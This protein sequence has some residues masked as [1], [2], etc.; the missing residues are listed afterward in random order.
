MESASER[1]NSRLLSSNNLRNSSNIVGLEFDDNPA[2]TKFDD[3]SKN[4]PD[5]TLNKTLM[6]GE[7]RMNSASQVVSPPDI[8]QVIASVELNTH[9]ERLDNLGRLTDRNSLDKEQMISQSMKIDKEQHLDPVEADKKA[10]TP[11]VVIQDSKQLDLSSSSA[12]P[13]ISEDL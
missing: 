3:Q 10:V 4:S 1:E 2:S 7:A 13:F 11:Q 6:R 5:M 8:D 12:A 9:T